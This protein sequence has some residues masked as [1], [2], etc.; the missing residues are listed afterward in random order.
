M[1]WPMVGDGWAGP[2]Y[3]SVCTDQCGLG[4]NSLTGGLL[5]RFACAL[6]AHLRAHNGAAPYHLSRLGAHG[7]LQ[8]LPARRGNPLGLG[9][10][11]DRH[12]SVRSRVLADQPV[13]GTTPTMTNDPLSQFGLGAIDLRWTLKDITAKRWTLTPVN[14]DN[15][16]RL[17]DLGLVEMRRTNLS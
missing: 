9:A 1:H 16:S 4:A 3:P 6:G 14:Q 8:P 12:P 17:I 10:E 15:L 2:P 5:C 11:R 13:K 7:P